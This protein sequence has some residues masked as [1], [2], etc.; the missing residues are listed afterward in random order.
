MVDIFA[1]SNYRTFLKDFYIDKKSSDPRFSFRIFAH[2]AGFKSKTFL[3][4]VMNGQKALAVNRT[5]TLCTVLKLSAKESRYF[6]K[7]VEFNDCKD[8]HQKEVYLDQLNSLRP[9]SPRYVTQEKYEYFSQW[10]HAVVRELCTLKA[11]GGNP[12]KIASMIPFGVKPRQVTKSLELLKK[13]NLIKASSD[14]TYSQTSKV[15]TTGDEV[16]SIAVR[17]FQQEMIQLSREALDTI[18]RE[19]R[20]I[21]TL[22]LGISGEGYRRLKELIQKFRKEFISIVNTIDPVDRVYQLNIQFFP[23]TKITPEQKDL[24]TNSSPKKA[25]NDSKGEE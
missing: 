17:K 24:K 13:L 14:G 20:E 6:K 19:H 9:Q 16:V 5:D 8:F 15:L 2:H 7:L 12:R 10:Y 4:K 3:F 25:G 1:Y 23:L 21:S 18:E 22:T 11:V